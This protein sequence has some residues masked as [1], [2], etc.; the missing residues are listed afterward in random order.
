MDGDRLELV[1]GLVNT[2]DVETGVDDLATPAAL[3]QWVL[4]HGLAAHEPRATA[5]DLRH[6]LGTREAVRAL[7]VANAGGPEPAAAWSTLERQ[8]RRSRVRLGF[9]AT[10]PELRAGATGVDGAL[11]VV[12]ADVAGAIADGTW[13]R[14]KACLADDCHWAFIDRTRNG[15]RRWCDMRICGNRD[16][17]R[18]FRARRAEAAPRVQG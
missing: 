15:S 3:A 12:L 1:R 17:V 16:K 6:A 5:R 11:G 10:G 18:A 9:A 2:L 7:L 13:P 4:D 8:A 14:L